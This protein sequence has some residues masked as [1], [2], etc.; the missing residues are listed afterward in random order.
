[1]SG[2]LKVAIDNIPE[3]GLKEKAI[4]LIAV[5]GGIA[6]MS[7]PTSHLRDVVAV[8]EG[9]AVSTGV[10]SFAEDFEKGENVDSRLS[11]EKIKGRVKYLAEAP[12][13]DSE[14]VRVAR[15]KNLA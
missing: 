12:F 11:S 2:L 15:E 7:Q 8:L 1:M 3:S 9:L 13:S 6:R 10:A 14:L 4:G 5:S